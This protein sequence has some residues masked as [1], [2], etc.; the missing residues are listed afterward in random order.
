MNRAFDT[1]GHNQ[2][3]LQ[4]ELKK[5]SLGTD[6]NGNWVFDVEAS[7]E[8]LDFEGQRILQNALLNSK[9]YF[10]TNGVVSKDHLHQR[11]HEGGKILYDESYVIGE[12]KKVYMRDGK[13]RVQGCLYKSNE[14]AREFAKL[15]N[16]NSTRVKASVGGLFP[17][18]VKRKEKGVDVGNVV[19]VLWNDLALTIAPVNPTVG[20]AVLVKSLSS[21]EF[22]RQIMPK[23]LSAGYGTDA[24]TFSGGRALQKEDGGHEKVIVHLNDE[25]AIASLVGAITDGDVEDLEEA[26]E[27]LNGYG[28]SKAVAREMIRGIVENSKEFMEVLP[29]AKGSLWDEIAGTAGRLRKALG[30][31][32]NEDV[33]PDKLEQGD[34]DGDNEEV[35]DAM[36][37]LKALAEHIERLEETNEIIAKSLAA[38]VEQNTQNTVIQ[39][40]IGESM[41]AIMEGQKQFASSPA[42]RRSAVSALDAMLKGGFGGGPAIPGTGGG[43]RRHRQFTHADL[44]D[45]KDIL[46]KAVAAKT[47]TVLE[48]TKAETQINKSILN[49]A[50]QIDEGFVKILREGAKA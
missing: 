50:Y 42:P 30:G 21:F 37:V 43:A 10:L 11:T 45:A 47:L 15:L 17:K 36:P 38:L 22:V 9:E 33:D 18:V 3:F 4:M 19:S 16:D 41:L 23:S 29:M 12:P 13:V 49:P 20:P 28:I 7:N 26:E 6:D 35:E 32:G 40:S 46:C 24:A 44:D 14:Y 39:K 5:G 48:A 2:V 1:A 27:F 25:A 8:N 31:D 34:D